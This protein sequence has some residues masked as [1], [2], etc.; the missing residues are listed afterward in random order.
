[1]KKL[2]LVLFLSLVATCFAAGPIFLD[3]YESTT[4]GTRLPEGYTSFGSFG[5]MGVSK[6]KGDAASGSMGGYV[7]I[8]FKTSEWGAGLAHYGLDLDLSEAVLS[9][10]IKSSE[11]FAEKDGLVAFRIS[12]ADGTVVRTPLADL[13]APK[14]AFAKFSQD[15]KKLTTVD[16][17]GTTPGIDLKHVSSIGLV[18]YKRENSSQACRFVFD[19][20]RAD[21]VK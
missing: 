6:A 18:F 13:Y 7:E 14:A 21:K 12:D 15:V 2:S 3:D 5:K 20:L 9:V 16:E 8:D 1:M 10:Q 11:D 4:P 19:D 17:P